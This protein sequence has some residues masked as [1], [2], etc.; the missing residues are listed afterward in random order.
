VG[1]LVAMVL[2]WQTLAGSRELDPAAAMHLKLGEEFLARRGN[3][4]FEQAITE[5]RQ[6]TD[7]NPARP[8]GWI[9]LAEAY[10]GAA[11]WGAMDTADGLR[12]AR[13][14]INRAVAVAPN[15]ARVQ[16]LLGYIASIDVERWLTAEPYFARAL[17]LNASDEKAQFWYA[18]HLGRLGRQDEAIALLTKVLAASPQ[19]FSIQ[20]QLA[21]EYFR[22]GRN[23]EFLTHAL[24]LARIQPNLPNSRLTLARAYLQNGRVAEA[25][26]ECRQAEKFGADR[27]QLLAV[28]SVVQLEDGNVEEARRS[29]AEMEEIWKTRP[30]NSNGLAAAFAMA[31]DAD[32]AVKYLASGFERGDSLVLAAHVTPWYVRIKDDP[33]FVAFVRKTGLNR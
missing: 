21:M 14:A 19:S 26:E 22:A 24:Q 4:D 28:L 10:S 12:Q 16:S 31:G 29:R 6:A 33:R 25:A 7:L 15:D 32:T 30:T 2:N 18:T 27:S 11:N 17:Q 8:E 9:G 3:G 1:A 20:H 23:P 13:D 5:F